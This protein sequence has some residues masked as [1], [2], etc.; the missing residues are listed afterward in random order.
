MSNMDH[1]TRQ[2]EIIPLE[3]LGQEITVIGAL[4]IFFF[5]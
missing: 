5:A 2:L 4:C 1:L 3:S